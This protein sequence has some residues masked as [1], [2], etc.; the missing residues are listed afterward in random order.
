[1]LFRSE[2]LEIQRS[3]GVSKTGK[4]RPESAD[5]IRIDPAGHRHHADCDSR[6]ADYCRQIVLR[7]TRQKRTWKSG[8]GTA[9]TLAV[10]VGL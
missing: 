7:K 8:E 1:M 2:P 10:E 5:T 4:M 3:I 9:E 6:T